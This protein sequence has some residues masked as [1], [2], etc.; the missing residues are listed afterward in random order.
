MLLESTFMRLPWSLRMAARMAWRESRSNPAKFAVAVISMTIGVG[1]MYAVSALTAGFSNHLEETAREWMAADIAVHDA[2]PPTTEQMEAISRLDSRLRW[3]LFVEAATTV[4]SDQSP[5]PVVVDLRVLDLNTYPFYGKL[6]VRHVDPASPKLDAS[7]V[8]VS[9]ATLESLQVRPGD[10]IRVHTT[11]FRIA[12]VIQSE[13]GLASVASSVLPHIVLSPEGLNRT[14]ILRFGSTESYQLLLK[15][16]PGI[17][18]LALCPRLEAL[19][20][21]AE[22]LHYTTAAHL[23]GENIDQVMAALKILSVLFLTF[24]ALG[25]AVATYLHVLQRFE[26]IAILRSLGATAPQVLHIY[27]IQVLFLALAASFFGIA[28]G[29]VTEGAIAALS[30]RYVSIPLQTGLRLNI[31]MQ[32]IGLALL[33]AGAAA[34]LPLSR[35][36]RVPAAILLRRDAGERQEWAW[37]LLQGSQWAAGALTVGSVLA[38]LLLI[39]LD[40]PWQTRLYVG[41]GLGAAIAALFAVARGTIAAFHRVIRSAGVRLPFLVRQSAGNLYRYR[42]QALVVML[43]LASGAA[44]GIVTFL[45]KRQVGEHVIDTSPLHATNLLLIAVSPAQ[46]QQ[47]L[48]LLRD[49]PDIKTQPQWTPMTWLTLVKAGGLDLEQLR[50]AHP[51]TWLQKNWFTTCADSAPN[52]IQLISGQWWAQDPSTVAAMALEEN[53]AERLGLRV[54]STLEILRNGSP[55]EVRVRA[56]MRVPPLQ[57]LWYSM[58]MNCS[59]FGEQDRMYYGGIHLEPAVLERVRRLLRRRMPELI[60]A[61]ATLVVRVS[62]RIEAETAQAVSF[63]AILVLAAAMFLLLS[64]TRA[65]RFFRIHEVAVLRAL[66]ARPRTVLAAILLEYVALGGLAG[67]IGVVLGSGA[68]T[69]VLSFVTGNIGWTFDAPGALIII[70][71]TALIAGGVGLFGSRTL[72]D[73]PPLET[74]RRQ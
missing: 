11:D 30:M 43:T 5:D 54:G 74:L 31:A 36:R 18:S 19:F 69:A 33:A 56:I 20:P 57:K 45:I 6:E 63:C 21:Y 67:L 58:I 23:V 48:Q 60:T 7:S 47:L 39:R 26:T 28:A 37:S 24:G 27:L 44:L 17:D 22:V 4:T 14:T 38:V 10:R 66:G 73:A 9:E 51:R 65:L 68:T 61:D 15:A 2:R 71:A 62:E 49:Q 52:S 42:R 41:A 25:V 50:A 53:T 59:T 29:R 64:V 55:M 72:L 34:W 40:V 35:I 1:G 16:P 3:T 12:G 13:P 32:D 8:W 70:I 46:R